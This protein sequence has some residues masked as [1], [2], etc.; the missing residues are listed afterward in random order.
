[1][2]CSID[3]AAEYQGYRIR[4]MKR[5]RPAYQC[6]IDTL[7]GR[8]DHERRN[9]LE[10]VLRRDR[11]ALTG[12]RITMPVGI[13]LQRVV[14]A[15]AGIFRGYRI[16]DGRHGFEREWRWIA[17]VVLTITERKLKVIDVLDG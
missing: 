4:G 2:P 10:F 8:I 16:A 3:I 7:G 6:V 14:G 15:L 9:R 11:G 13:S 5:L 12:L 17:F 1:M